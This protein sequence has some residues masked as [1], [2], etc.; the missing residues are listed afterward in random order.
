MIL[1]ELSHVIM[2]SD[3]DE[4]RPTAI[5]PEH[6]P[7]IPAD[8]EFIHIRTQSTNPQSTVQM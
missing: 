6:H 5:K 2:I 4:F 7:Q 1:H 3:Q 8:P